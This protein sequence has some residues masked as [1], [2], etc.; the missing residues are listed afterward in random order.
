MGAGC[1]RGAIADVE[2]R[3]DRRVE[4]RIEYIEGGFAIFMM[5]SAS[6]DIPR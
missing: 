2:R 5:D 6:A 3:V 1:V 4:E